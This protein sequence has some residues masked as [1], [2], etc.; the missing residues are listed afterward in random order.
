MSI[1]ELQHDTLVRV[2]IGDETAPMYIQRSN[3]TSKCGLFSRI[4]LHQK[5]LGHEFDTLQ[6]PEDDLDAWKTMMFWMV[7]GVLPE[8]VKG[9][10]KLHLVCCWCLG[11]ECEVPEFQDSIMVE[12][13]VR[14][15]RAIKLT[16]ETTEDMIA[17]AEYAFSH[18]EDHRTN[19]EKLLLLLAETIH[20]HAIARQDL[21][22]ARFS[23]LFHHDSFERLYEKTFDQFGYN[24]E[25]EYRR[26]PSE[27]LPHA[28]RW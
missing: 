19:D 21:L 7:S 3:L 18:S 22:S 13:L 15:E 5:K 25:E 1:S 2:F 20:E 14:V 24:S 17:A 12:L 9:N 6:Y 11:S 10:T 4:A 28:D 16:S 8:P 27:K 23:F 26:L